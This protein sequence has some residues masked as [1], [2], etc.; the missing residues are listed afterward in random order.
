MGSLLILMP[1]NNLNLFFN[2]MAITGETIKLNQAFP[3]GPPTIPGPHSLPS[4]ANQ[5]GIFDFQY[6]LRKM[7]LGHSIIQ[8]V[9]FQEQV[10]QYHV[11]KVIYF[12]LV[13]IL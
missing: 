4:P 2:T 8:V 10:L 12:Y 1:F 11:M 13:V 7:I 3:P 9:Q 6:I 5:P